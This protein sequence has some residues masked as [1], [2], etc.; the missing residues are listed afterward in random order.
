M[1]WRSVLLFTILST[2]TLQAQVGVDTTSVSALRKWMEADTLGPRWVN[3]GVFSINFTQVSLYNWAAGGF[4]SLSGIS[5]FNGQANW[6]SGRRA[7]DNTVVLAFGGQRQQN[8]ISRKTEDR[9]ELSTKYGYRL[10][11]FWY[12]A[13][14]AQLRTQF[15][16]G[17]DEEGQRISHF[18]APGYVIGGLGLDYRPRDNFSIFISP[19]TARLVLVQ[20]ATLW[21]VSEEADFM[22]YGVERGRDRV[23][24]FGGL[25][26]LQYSLEFATNMTFTTRGDVFSNYLNK[27]GNLDVIW[28][29]LWNF[30]VNEWFAATL[31][32]LLIYDHDVRIPRTDQEGNLI[33]APATQFKETLSVGFTFKL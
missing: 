11:E 10:T 2:T 9:I 17:F 15:T 21:D 12:V 28:E 25:F 24:Q 13:A 29:T 23:L 1:S 5:M 3:S 27:P 26:R 22:V 33:S 6:Q 18:M 30:K 16:E 14:L 19:G 8:N 4:S 31:N 7:W 32:T 20:D